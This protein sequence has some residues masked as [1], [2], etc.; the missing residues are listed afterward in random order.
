MALSGTFHNYPVSSFGLYCEWSASQSVTGNYSD[1]TL[2]VYLSYYTLEVGARNDATVAINGTSETYSTERIYDYSSGWKKK[3]L[4]TKTVRVNHA[5]NGTATN[6][7]LSASW[8]FSGTYSDVQIGTI[9]ASTTV[10]LNSIDRAAPT[11]SISTSGITA[12]AVTVSATASTTCDIW[13]YSTNNGSAWTQFST[14]AGTT[15]STTISGLSPNTSYTI[16]V[17]ARKKTNQVYGTSSGTAITTLGNAILNSVTTVTADN[18]TATI[19]FNRTIYSS[20]FTYTLEIKNGSTSVLTITIP[21]QTAGTA[22]QTITLTS[23]QR[24]TLLNSFPSSKSFTGTFVLTT[25]SGSTTIGNTSSKTATVQTTAANSAPTFS[26]SAGFTYQDGNTSTANV[27]GNNQLLIQGYSTL[28]VT[29]YAATAKNGASISKYEATINDTT[30]SSSTTSMNLGAMNKSG[31]LTLTV[32]AVDSRGYSVTV[33]KTII[34]IAYSKI[35]ISEGETVM[36]RVNE[37]EALT[38]VDFAASISKILVSNVNKNALVLLR[39]RYKKT[40]DSSY[41]SYTTI[42]AQATATDTKITFESDE[43]ISL[44]PDY[45]YNVQFYVSDKVTSDTYVITLPQGTPLISKRR[46]K[47]GIN[48][49]NPARALDVTGE[50]GMNGFNVMGLVEA[51]IPDETD[52]N[53]VVEPGIYFRRTQADTANHYPTTTFGM[54]EVFS[55]DTNVVIQRYTTRDSPFNMYMRS[56]VNGT[57]GAW[58]SK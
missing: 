39:Y 56:R 6:I 58:V 35:D 48:N 8:R 18:A 21:A 37:V 52:L 12:S 17:R 4:K 25:K 16:K 38:Q 19:V 53:S 1:V 24:T 31:N 22:N 46:K 41:G 14:T 54:L 29:A 15:A 28:S 5:S 32:K 42:T 47:V 11:V 57:W 27:T 23:A 50:I 33:S 43:F 40:S 55:C 45:S 36:R 49:R 3:L 13:Q 51:A 26:N 30:V 9:T 7:P 44:D 20:S 10:D 34:V 2:K